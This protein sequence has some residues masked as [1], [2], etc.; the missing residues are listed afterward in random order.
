MQ[1]L[2]LPIIALLVFVAAPCL[3]QESRGSI[4][5]TVSDPQGAVVP[6]AAVTITNTE[7]NVTNRTRTNGVGYFEANLLNP[8]L[9]S[10]SVEAQGFKK[11]VRD[12]L[13]LNVAG[14]M[15]I[16]MQLELGEAAQVV[17]ITAEAPLLDTTS[18]AGGRLVDTKELR[19]LPFP[20]MNPLLLQAVTA[21]MQFTGTPG[22]NRW[23]DHAGT[24]AYNA[25]GNVGSNEY[26]IDGAPV[27]GTAGR[28]GFVPTSEAVEEFRLETLPLDASYG[29][30]GGAVV[31]MSTR[32][33][34]NEFHGN[35]YEQHY[36][37]RW[38]ALPHFTRLQWEADV[39]AGRKSADSP[40]QPAGRYNQYGG[41]V[42][43]PVRIPK[44]FDGRDKLFFYFTYSSIRSNRVEPANFTVPHTG[45]RGSG[46][47]STADFSDIL[48]IDAVKY[49][50]YD[51]RSARSQ[52]GRTVR[53]PFPGNK[54]IPILNPAYQWWLPLYPEPNNVPGVVT[55]DG[56]DNWYAAGRPFIDKGGNIT[57]RTDYNIS[58]KHRVF[59]KWFWNDRHSDEYDWAYS[60]PRKGLISQSLLRYTKGLSTDYLYTINPQHMLNL[61]FNF[62]RYNEGADP[63]T[64]RIQVDTKP[65]DLGL[66][67]YLD[68]KAGSYVQ[69]PDF[70]ITGIASYP[71]AR[72]GASYPKADNFS[73]N[74]ELKAGMMSVVG[75]HSLK[76]GW[77][78]RRYWYALGS[79]GA[80]TGSYTFNNT[81]MKQQD[82]T[83]T[84]SDHGL[85]WAAFLMGLPS[86]VTIPT[87]DTSFWSTRYRAFYLQDNL[88]LSSRLQIGFGLRY[89]R[90]TGITERLNRG[91]NGGFDFGYRPPFADAVEAAYARSP[92]PELA[93]SQFK[94]AGGTYYLGAQGQPRTFTDGTHDF[95]PNGSVVYRLNDKTVLRGGY[96]WS[97]DTRRATSAG[98]PGQNG[99]SQATNTQVSNDLG[100]TFC[101]GVGDAANLGTTVVLANPFPVRADGTRF[102][103]PLGNSMGPNILQGSSVSITPRDIRRDRQQRWRVSFQREITKNMVIDVSYN[104]SYARMPGTMNL[105]YLPG[106]YWSKGNVRDN[107]QNTFL[108]A[109]FPNPFRIT[110]LTALQ[111]SNPALYNFLSTNS[112][113]TA[114][115][116]QRQQLLRAYPSF[117]ALNGIA[118]GADSS[119]YDNKMKYHDLQIQFERRYSRGL[120]T[121]VAYTRGYSRTTYRANEYDTEYSWQEN[122]A[123]KPHRLA[124]TAIY[125]LPFGKGR[126][127]VTESPLRHIVGGWQMS[128]IYQYQTGSASSWAN[129]FFYGDL[130]QIASLMRHD[131]VHSTD[132][133][134]WFDPNIAYKTGTAAIPSGFTGFEGRSA[135]QPTTYHARMFPALLDALRVDGIFSLDA[136]IK[137]Q[138]ILHEQV[139]L[140][141]SV[142]MMN[143]TNH[144]NFGAPNTDPTSTSFGRVTTQAGSGRQIQV[145]LRLDF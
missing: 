10:V 133:H 14:R 18:A 131:D 12:G 41:S 5:G 83:T 31:N 61:N 59:V 68:E 101:C 72:G 4:T 120:R 46:P 35:L 8:G 109:T 27:T 93:A 7:T 1:R 17:Q 145:N 128:W 136:Q 124:W 122:T 110:N 116:L 100:L 134:A 117:T 126:T 42:G 115:T 90:E 85:G 84:A 129:R 15:N 94:V 132:I 40:K 127:W 74:S 49:T 130:G 91:L 70:N 79:L 43:G 143:A 82:N 119:D 24:S 71:G 51:P 95:L 103:T 77:S 69:T 20:A 25:M 11:S 6:G 65:S 28:V 138:F 140:S 80:T 2:L 54:G 57:Q 60:T 9:Y 144:T 34:T 55:A 33:G 73:T 22:Y 23:F 125:E 88:N 113:F 102:D 98:R 66:P 114:T 76:Y 75:R 97:F 111:S 104:G 29:Y 48:A 36:Q 78:E 56:I 64:K 112:R 142:D 99:Y 32:S 63:N 139:K 3:A 108:T 141:A 81:Y 53:T 92:M 19:D 38:N 118:P 26:T 106:Q 30:T 135:F 89:E 107:A 13:Q 45:W 47:G 58:D 121:V 16:P 37:T 50:I 39:A 52:G 86:T 67:K 105:A 21:G 96:T 87:N 123:V 44:V 62:S 137:R